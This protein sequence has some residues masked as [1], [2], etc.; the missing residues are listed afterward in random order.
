MARHAVPAAV[1]G[2]R[3]LAAPYG[4]EFGS[5]GARDSFG[6][7]NANVHGYGRPRGEIVAVGN[8]SLGTSRFWR[9]EDGGLTFALQQSTNAGVNAAYVCYHPGRK[10]Y[11]ATNPGQRDLWIS[12][13]R[14][15]TWTLAVNRLPDGPATNNQWRR[16]RYVHAGPM[17]G[18]IVAMQCTNATG[19]FVDDWLAV[20]TDGG[21]TFSL[22]VTGI[23]LDGGV[24]GIAWASSTGRYVF[25]SNGIQAN[26]DQNRVV[27]S[28]DLAAFNLQV[29]TTGTASDSPLIAINALATDIFYAQ[30]IDFLSATYSQTQAGFSPRRIGSADGGVSWTLQSSA[31]GTTD[32]TAG[33]Q[34][35]P[36]DQVGIMGISISGRK[37][38]MYQFTPGTLFYSRVASGLAAAGRHNNVEYLPRARAFFLGIIG[39]AVGNIARSD[40]GAIGSFAEVVTVIDAAGGVVGFAES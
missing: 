40:D 12:D 31:G 14:G 20:S 24:C 3:V 2:N 39:G 6:R 10:R 30:A 35:S 21:D 28:P 8:N 26:P 15:L 27:W 29:V 36:R 22:V 11:L 4:D 37:D 19:G 25:V 33:N 17:T 5:Q 13:D 9:S 32:S 18:A 7:A 23:T 16:I 1:R 34:F 38:F